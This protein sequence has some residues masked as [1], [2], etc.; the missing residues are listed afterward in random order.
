MGKQQAETLNIPVSFG[1]VSVGAEQ[2][3]IGCK[4][5]RNALVLGKADYFLCE[6]RCN[7]QITVDPEAAGD[8]PGQQKLPGADEETKLGGTADIKGFNVRS[9]S[10]GFGLTFALTEIDAGN[11]SHFAGK[12]GRLIAVRTGDAGSVAL[13]GEDGEGDE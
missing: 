12:S 10:I 5:E 8:A 3:R 4:V 1:G 6:S 11:L 7:V 2:A 9:G 13:A